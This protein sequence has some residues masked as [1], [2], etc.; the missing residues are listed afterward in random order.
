MPDTALPT[1]RY[2]PDPIATG[3]V[4][5]SMAVFAACGQC[6]GFA[7][8]RTLYGPHA[9]DLAGRICPWRIADGRAAQ[10]LGVSFVDDYPLL[11]AALPLPL[12]EEV[13]LRTPGY[14]SWQGEHWKSHCGD[15]CS[16]HRD[17]S[18]ADVAAATPESIAE[19]CA[20]HQ[21]SAQDWTL[22][23]SGYVPGGDSALY[24]FQ[25][26]HCGLTLFGWD[27]S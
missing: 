4:V 9:Q 27:L 15:A 8:V 23:T 11:D 14:L 24:R 3:N 7:Y 6:R 10:A 17:A 22:I 21:Q 1:F 19:W 5:A 16:F 18:V 26:L 20:A 12:V 25:C 13:T 2:H